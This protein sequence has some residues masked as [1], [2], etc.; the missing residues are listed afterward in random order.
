MKVFLLVLVEKYHGS[1]IALSNPFEISSL[2]STVWL[3]CYMCVAVFISDHSFLAK[4]VACFFFTLQKFASEA[5]SIL[6]IELSVW[7]FNLRDHLK[8]SSQTVGVELKLQPILDHFSRDLVLKLRH[9]QNYLHHCLPIM[10]I[11]PWS[12]GVSFCCSCDNCTQISILFR[13]W[14]SGWYCRVWINMDNLSHVV[15]HGMCVP[16]LGTGKSF[17]HVDKV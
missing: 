16:L 9:C 15:S 6:T 4:P 1:L 17:S 14:M 12:W 5:Q 7:R 11:N 13:P 8:A 2:W 3:A 10:T